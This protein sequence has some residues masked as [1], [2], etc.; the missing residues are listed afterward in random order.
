MHH[1]PS[2]PPLSARLR[3]AVSL[4][5]FL[6]RRPV[7][8]LAL[9]VVVATAV[10]AAVLAVPVVSAP[11]GPP[12]PVAL[13][14]SSSRSPSAWLATGHSAGSSTGAPESST[15]AFP[16][17]TPPPAPAAP[18]TGSGP[19]TPTSPP[20]AAAAPADEPPSSPS[21]TGTT[22]A[23]APS[24]SAAATTAG[25]HPSAT[26]SSPTATPS[27]SGSSA[28]APAAVP[29]PAAS[30]TT[31]TAS[32]GLSAEAQVLALVNEHREQ[33][34]CGALDADA[35]LAAV[36]RAHSADM[37]DRNFFDHVNPAG[38]DPFARA[39]AA[40]VTAR[41]ENIAR[42]QSDASAVMTSWMNSPG[43]R[44]NILDCDLDRLGVGMVEGSGGPFWTQL[45]G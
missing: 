40:G 32:A 14:S 31:A 26:S 13:D 36:A 28:P 19:G 45:F 8:R 35:G 43:H 23:P 2:G 12:V 3:A 41:A 15:S 17:T 20:P 22:P 5:A 21:A 16:G 10:T 6:V 9:A 38:E 44:A 42:G 33:A 18:S 27:S 24:R 29:G 7:R 34:G 39:T 37:R 11:P 30:T 25:A 1:R 4:L